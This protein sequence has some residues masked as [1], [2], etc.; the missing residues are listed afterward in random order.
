MRQSTSKGQR[1]SGGFGRLHRRAGA[2]GLQ[3][4]GALLVVVAV[5]LGVFVSHA[6]ADRRFPIRS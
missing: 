4:F 6:G 2:F 5:F 3:L 1:S